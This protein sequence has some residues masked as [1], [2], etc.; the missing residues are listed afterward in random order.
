MYFIFQ[1]WYNDAYFHTPRVVQQ[2]V[3]PY[4]KSSTMTR[5]SLFQGSY[6]ETWW[7]VFRIPIYFAHSWKS[8]QYEEAWVRSR[9]GRLPCPLTPSMF[10]KRSRRSTP[11]KKYLY[12]KN[13][14]TFNFYNF[15]FH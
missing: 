4:F 14:T 15:I 5:I 8:V 9:E 12:D 7:P 11:L 2:Y 13:K 6:K 10:T 1:K 3:F